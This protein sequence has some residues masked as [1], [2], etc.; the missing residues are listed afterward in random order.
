ME[1]PLRAGLEH[2]QQPQGQAVPAVPVLTVFGRQ[3][4][5]LQEL[6][7]AMSVNHWLCEGMREG[8]KREISNKSKICQSFWQSL[9]SMCES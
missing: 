5:D 6:L 4:G 9:E 1:L 3:A 8:L 7:K 2:C